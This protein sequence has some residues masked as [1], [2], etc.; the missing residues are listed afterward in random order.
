MGDTADAKK[1]LTVSTPKDCKRPPGF[2]RQRQS[3]TTWNPSSSHWTTT[4]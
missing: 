3:W 4:M 1:I 2:L